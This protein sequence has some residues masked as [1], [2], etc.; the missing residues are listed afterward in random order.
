MLP[1][2]WFLGTVTVTNT[3]TSQSRTVKTDAAGYY[4]AEALVPATYDVQITKE[5]FNTQTTQGVKVDPSTR[6]AV[7]AA[8]AVGSTVTKVNVAAS[9]VR[10]ETESGA[11]SGVISGNQVNQIELNGRNYVQLSVLVPGV[12]STAGMTEAVSGG[13]TYSTNISVN[14][15]DMQLNN[16]SVD[17]TYN[18][19]TGAFAS[20]NVVTPLDSISEFNILKD[21]YSAKY[22]VLGSAQIQVDTKSGTQQFHGSAYDYV[23]NQALDASNFFSGGFKTPLKQNNFGF[24]L[25]G[26]LYIPGHYNTDKT[27]TFFFVNEE[28][29]IRHVGDTLRGA[30]FPQAIRDGDLSAS[31][32]LHAGGLQLDAASAALSAQEHPGVQCIASATALMPR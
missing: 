29:H 18:M 14:G 5:G 9:S 32:T 20:L 16:T 23:R 3:A 26:P 7:N 21:N 31:P 24:S 15:G 4:A 1:E 22:G 19:N 11:S 8:L 28:W 10:V 25:G 17:G 2:R 6:V 27:K 12:V 30:V 13:L